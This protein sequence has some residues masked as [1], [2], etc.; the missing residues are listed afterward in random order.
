MFPPLHEIVTNIQGNFQAWGER[1]KKEL[2]AENKP[3]LNAED[4]CRKMDERM[5]KFSTRMSFINKDKE[6]AASLANRRKSV[7]SVGSNNPAAVANKV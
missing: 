4:E 1:R 5:N 2:R 3:E 7:S 6:V